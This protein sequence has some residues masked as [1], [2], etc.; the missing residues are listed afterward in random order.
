M[1]QELSKVVHVA[2]RMQNWSE[3]R[4]WPIFGATSFFS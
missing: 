3:G 1:F 4:A 2:E